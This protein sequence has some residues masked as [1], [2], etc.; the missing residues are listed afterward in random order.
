MGKRGMP[1][2]SPKRSK[3]GKKSK[4]KK[5]SNAMSAVPLATRWRGTE[6]K[7]ILFASTTV[8]PALAT[9]TWITPQPVNLVAQGTGD[10]QYVGRRLLMKSITYRWSIQCSSVVQGSQ[11]RLLIFYDAQTNGGNPPLTMGGGVDSVLTTD[12]NTGLMQLDNTKRFSVIFDKEVTLD[13]DSSNAAY[14][15]GYKKLQ[16]E[17]VFLG[18][19]AVIASVAKGGIFVSCVQNGNI[20][21]TALTSRFESRVRFIDA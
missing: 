9:A 7:E 1:D 16:H 2:G 6:K 18:A 11:I 14:S 21:T 3:K 12:T 15:Q 4:K 10:N 5:A 8:F 13:T 19:T 17:M 20:I